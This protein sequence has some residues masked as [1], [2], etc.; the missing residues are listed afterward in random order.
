[1]HWNWAHDDFRKVVLNA[2]AWCAGADVP[3][4]GIQSTTPD[5]EALQANQNSK[6]GKSFNAERVQKLI[7]SFEQ[8]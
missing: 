5:L 2:I 8:K 1:M 6:P 7:D 4:G 3:E